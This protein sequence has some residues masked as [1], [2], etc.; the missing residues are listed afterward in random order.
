MR[1]DEATEHAHT[2]AHRGKWIM[3][4]CGAFWRLTLVRCGPSIVDVWKPWRVCEQKVKCPKLDLRPWWWNLGRFGKIR[5]EGRD[6]PFHLSFFLSTELRG[7]RGPPS[8]LLSPASQP[9]PPFLWSCGR[10]Q[11]CCRGQTFSQK[12]RC[13]AKGRRLEKGSSWEPTWPRLSLWPLSSPC[14]G[15]NRKKWHFG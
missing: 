1:R 6:Q 3:L 12:P 11:S 10:Q 14:W 8:K 5:H 7:T 9:S 4:D 15:S 2:Q 13:A